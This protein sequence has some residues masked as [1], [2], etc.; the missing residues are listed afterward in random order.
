MSFSTFAL[1]CLCG[2]DLVMPEELRHG[3]CLDCRMYCEACGELVGVIH[4]DGSAALCDG[5]E[6]ATSRIP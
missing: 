5:C 1:R 2:A 4:R 3:S 6:A